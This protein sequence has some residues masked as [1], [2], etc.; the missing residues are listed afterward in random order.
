MKRL[1]AVTAAS[2]LIAATTVAEVSVT[3]D[4][5]SAYV[6]R[7]TTAV[8]DLVVQPGIEVSG[9]GLKEECGSIA[10]GVWGSTAPF[11]DTYDNLH[12]TD[13][14]AVYTLPELVTNLN[15]SFGFT[16]YQYFGGLGEQEINLVAD[17]ALCEVVTIGGSVNFMVDDEITATEDQIY[18]DLYA[19]YAVEVSEDLDASV[20]ALIGLM[21]QGDGND[22]AGLNDGLNQYELNAAFTYAMNEMWSVGASLAY[23]GQLDDD[24]LTDAAYDRGLVAMLSIGC[25]M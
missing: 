23:I 22:A 5:A 10:L 4:V 11:W 16:E 2:G 13:W 25:D 21:K 1:L 18:V 12:E 9:F 20:G 15:L 8:D 24:V 3:M 6:F 17:Y 7:G 14:Y 19:D